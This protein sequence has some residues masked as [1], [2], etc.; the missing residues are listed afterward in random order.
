MK[1]KINNK[2]LLMLILFF[3]QIG[4]IFAQDKPTELALKF[5][6]NAGL[7]EWCALVLIFF[8]VKAYCE[9]L[10]FFKNEKYKSILIIFSIFMSFG[11]LFVLVTG[12]GEDIFKLIVFSILEIGVLGL[13]FLDN[14]LPLYSKMNEKNSGPEKIKI[15]LKLFFWISVLN[16]FHIFMEITLSEENFLKND[17]PFTFLMDIIK[18]NTGINTDWGTV[19][20]LII[21]FVFI[22]IMNLGIKK[23][24]VI[25]NLGD[26]TRDEREEVP[27]PEKKQRIKKTEHNKK[28]ITFYTKTYNKNEFSETDIKEL[29]D[30]MVK[31]INDKTI[32]IKEDEEKFLHIIVKIIE[33][34]EEINNNL[35]TLKTALHNL[36]E[37]INK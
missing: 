32:E 11:L 24:N 10:D 16:F 4:S 36:I 29:I 8:G 3:N 27:K 25:E 18:I 20:V 26:E 21:I 2:I 30:I 14:V 9:K 22:M 33:K 17:S 37:E 1:F 19:V 6:N 5:I 35:D 28:I 7:F 13:I 15:Y 31:I 34:N 12:G 23:T